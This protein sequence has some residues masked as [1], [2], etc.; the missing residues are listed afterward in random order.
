MSCTWG[1]SQRQVLE[2]LLVE[3]QPE[4]AIDQRAAS[5]AADTNDAVPPEAVGGDAV[6]PG[7]TPPK[8]VTGEVLLL[9]RQIAD[10][11]HAHTLE[12]DENRTAE[13]SVTTLLKRAIASERTLGEREAA[14]RTVTSNKS[15]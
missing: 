8:T 1:M 14:G 3:W 6:R 4:E 11:E 10:L 13:A 5:T 9:R 7:E 15:H 12:R 2:R